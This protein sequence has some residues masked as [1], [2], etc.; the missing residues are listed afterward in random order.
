MAETRKGVDA[1]DITLDRTI[2]GLRVN[3]RT[4]PL[5]E[6]FMRIM[7]AGETYPIEHYGRHWVR[8]PEGLL[9]VYDIPSDV[10]GIQVINTRTFYR[11][12]QPGRALVTMDG[13][14]GARTLNMAF[15][16]L[17][18]SSNEGGITFSINGV[19]SADD[20]IWLGNTIREA[21]RIVYIQY[22][23]PMEVSVKIVDELPTAPLQLETDV[24]AGVTNDINF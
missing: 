5:V 7:S 17:V 11:L 15:L 22:M 19:H 23:K 6:E 16:R 1:I 4:H 13:V 9:E 14:N 3:F 21:A 10:C 2:K 12:D 18:G 20:I 24:R 8:Q